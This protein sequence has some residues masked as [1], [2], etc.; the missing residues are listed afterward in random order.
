MTSLP[1]SAGA[2]RVAVA[3][4]N[5]S[6]IDVHFGHAEIF[7]IYDIDAAG[8]RLV[9]QR[10]VEHYCQG[11]YGDDDKRDA[12]LRA[13]ADCRACFVARAGDGPRARLAAA[14]IAPVCDYPFGA[15]E[16]SL[17]D[18]FRQHASAA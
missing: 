17:S 3:S 15:V 5:G 6:Q 11:G 9:D 18:W 14:G 16:E 10:L 12:I 4:K 1:L 8:P 2:L 7:S 13:I